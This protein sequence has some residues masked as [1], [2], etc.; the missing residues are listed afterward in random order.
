MLCWKIS[1]KVKI[2][3]AEKHLTI[4]PIMFK[5]HIMAEKWQ[6]PS[7]RWLW[8]LPNF[9]PMSW[10]FKFNESIIVLRFCGSIFAGKIILLRIKLMIWWKYLRVLFSLRFICL[11]VCDRVC[12][13]D[14]LEHLKKKKAAIIVSMWCA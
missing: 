4:K 8:F 9:M 2:I 14:Y 12:V 5:L 10:R 3:S 7:N 1:P 11:G 6:T 13:C